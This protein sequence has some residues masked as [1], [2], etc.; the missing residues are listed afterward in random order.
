MGWDI[1]DENANVKVDVHDYTQDDNN[2]VD[3]LGLVPYLGQSLQPLP[4]KV[5]T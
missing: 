5:N 3:H 2:D 1:E 4:G